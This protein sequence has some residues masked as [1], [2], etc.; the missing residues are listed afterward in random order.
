M[1][2]TKSE[3]YTD[4]QNQL[5]TRLKALAHPARLAIVQELLKLESCACGHF[6]EET[7]LAQP[8][9]FRHLKELKAAGIIKGNVSGKHV[10]YCIDLDNWKALQNQLQQLFAAYTPIDNCC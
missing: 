5:A 10:C 7:G 4:Q 6:V 9:V 3:N 8:T 2:L 1:G